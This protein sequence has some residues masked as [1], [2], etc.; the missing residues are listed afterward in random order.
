MIKTHR[1]AIYPGSFD[2][3]TNGHADLIERASKL[4]DRVIVA[5]G[6]NLGKTPLLTVD[7]RVGLLEEIVRP[8]G[9]VEVSQFDTLLVHYAKEMEANVILRGLRAVSDFEFE[10]Q[11]AGMNRR[12]S[13]DLETVF[14]TPL[15]QHAFISSTMIREIV[16]LGGDVSGFVPAV[17]HQ[18]LKIKYSDIV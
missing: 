1:T 18:Q 3:A 6:V 4:F 5:V 9:N 16:R 14:L 8:L 2:P 11:L 15:E 12:L 7:E 10:F 13:P 17:V